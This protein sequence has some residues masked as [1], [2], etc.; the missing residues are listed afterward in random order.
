MVDMIEDPA[1]RTLAREVLADRPVD[2]SVQGRQPENGS[3]A[4]ERLKARLSLQEEAWDFKGC[5]RFIRHFVAVKKRREGAPLDEQIR[6][7]EREHDEERLMQLLKE[8]QRWI[9]EARAYQRNA[10]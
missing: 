6:Q 3:E 5:Q 9:H 7:A 8:K 4:L 10:E 1:L 2:R